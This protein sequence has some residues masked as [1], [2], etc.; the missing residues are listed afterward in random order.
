M[1]E[2]ETTVVIS[3]P[4]ESGPVT[5]TL[6]VNVSPFCGDSPQWSSFCAIIS[7]NEKE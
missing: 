5:V 1:E 3:I 6:A 2:Y 7:L 4:A